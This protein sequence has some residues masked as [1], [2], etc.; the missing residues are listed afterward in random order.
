M[1]KILIVDNLPQTFKLNKEN[2]IC[3]NAFYGDINNDKNT[4]KNLAEIL[5]EIRFDVEETNDIRISLKKR[6]NL[7]ISKV[8]SNEF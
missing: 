5:E 6:E 8:T 2:G 4:L 1:N 7:I 3:I